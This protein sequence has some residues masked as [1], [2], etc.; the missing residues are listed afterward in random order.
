VFDNTGEHIATINRLGD[1]TT[2]A[3]TSGRLTSVTLPRGG[4]TYMFAY[5]GNQKLA[6]VTAPAV[7]GA[8]RNVT[9]SMT[10]GRLI[11]LTDPDGFVTTFAHS[12]T[13]TNVMM[14][15]RDKHNRERTFTHDG[16]G[17][18]AATAV[19][20]GAGSTSPI[21]WAM[22]AAESR[23]V[24][25]SGACGASTPPDTVNARTRIDGPRAVADT[26]NIAV[27]RYGAVNR[28]RDPRGSTSTFRRNDTR[29]PGRVTESVDPMGFTQQYSYN[30]RGNVVQRVDLNVFGSTVSPSYGYVYGS[31]QWPDG[32]T[33]MY[34][35]MGGWVEFT[36]DSRGNVLS[37]QD[38]RGAAGRMTFSYGAA[39][40]SAAN[41]LVAVVHPTV[42]AG[43][44]DFDS[45]QYDALGNVSDARTASRIGGTTTIH[46]ATHTT[47]DAIGRVARV[48]VDTS[49]GVTPPQQC[50]ATLFDRM[51]RDS[52]VTISAPLG[53]G[54]QSL[55]TRSRYDR[56]GRLVWLQRQSSLPDSGIGAI[57]TQWQ[58]DSAGRRITET[59]PDGFM[60][61]T[62]YDPAGNA[63]RVVTRKN[64]TLAM[65]YGLAGELLTRRLS[66]VRYTSTSDALIDTL[67]FPWKP[68]SGSDYLI[69]P[70]TQRFTYDSAMRMLTA[71]NRHA[72]ITRTYL[73]NGLL[74]SERQR[75]RGANDAST[76][77]TKH[78][79]LL[80]YQYDM[81]SRRKVVK[82][83]QQLTAVGQDSVLAVWH[84]YLDDVMAIVEPLGH[85]FT[86]TN[87]ERGDPAELDYPN[88]YKQL[89]TYSAAGYDSLDIITNTS[90]AGGRLPVS[91]VRSARSAFDARGFRRWHYDAAGFRDTARFTYTGMGHLAS[92]SISQQ[93]FITAGSVR[94]G[95]NEW[96]TYDALGNMLSDSTTTSKTTRVGG[97]LNS[98]VNRAD[99]TF[100]YRAQYQPN[101]GRI[102]RQ[103]G[104]VGGERTYT[105]DAAG[106]TQ[107]YRRAEGSTDESRFRERR[108]SYYAADGTLAAADYRWRATTLDDDRRRVFETYRYDALG[109]RVSVR[110][111]RECN[112][113]ND[114]G[115]DR[116]NCDMSTLQRT[117][118]DG[119][120]EL[121]E[122]QLPVKVPTRPAEPDSVLDNDVFEP[123]YPRVLNNQDPNPFFGRIVYTYGLT[124]D[125][126]V[127]LTR[128]GY[129]DLFTDT[130]RVVF[131]QKTVS[132]MW[133]ALGKM[134]A[135]AC[136]DGKAECSHTQNGRTANLQL[137]LPN[138]WFMYERP[139]FLPS[140][141][142]GTL[143]TDKQTATGT[144]Y[145]QNRYYDPG[146]GRFTK[147][148][149]IGL[150]GGKV[151][152]F[153][154]TGNCKIKWQFV[155]RDRPKFTRQNG[156]CFVSSLD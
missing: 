149:P 140:A 74:A 104:G 156:R 133:S 116:L 75:L 143:L 14:S 82:W 11:T 123:R 43:R 49:I 65:T 50:T 155:S 77:F 22:C 2:F 98:G 115:R 17:R 80:T 126:P 21:T 95:S 88:G 13:V 40:T 51:D 141:F 30:D 59:A 54:T 120:R 142:S 86:Y 107:W 44:T 23:G 66:A 136:A 138:L 29:F 106:N 109:R 124:L 121:I 16:T 113:P 42:L 68:N 10:S 39:G 72:Q 9:A 31:A 58:Y 127:A 28:I 62:V 83:P 146:A 45:L 134:G 55:T 53:A 36:Y 87:N 131:P 24:M 93:G 35:P 7:A 47:H 61:H 78:D 132:L 94:A 152:F 38:A 103:V 27:N 114:N 139:K 46:A 97:G 101:V 26:W 118:W 57:T 84:P 73:P 32:V 110:A 89:W 25:M 90:T 63:E 48:C 1:T 4:L 148:D 144:H 3:R 5:D 91:P 137:G 119:E 145:R 79:Y 81:N 67:P 85:V 70:D 100:G 56:E 135:A 92:S 20:A 60:E 12:P 64:D 153:S 147:E 71:N 99:Q 108:L 96:L 8:P 15:R 6:Q 128:Y 41:L 130:T 76:D 37:R 33:T 117:V 34:M 19:Y 102:T 52:V 105:Y 150:S 69:L 129:V 151:P 112:L 18:L 154:R 122:I 125:Q 111:D